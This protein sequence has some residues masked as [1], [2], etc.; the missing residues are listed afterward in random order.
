MHS[1]NLPKMY[2]IGALIQLPEFNIL[3][4]EKNM[5]SVIIKSFFR[6]KTGFSSI[7]FAIKSY[8]EKIPTLPKSA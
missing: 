2:E 4:L 1:L 5:F 7:D 8:D 6:M 3:S